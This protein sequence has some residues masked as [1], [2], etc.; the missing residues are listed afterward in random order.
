[1]GL[2]KITRL[3][4]AVDDKCYVEEVTSTST[5]NIIEALEAR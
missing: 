5:S 3:L 1:M 4:C 2:L